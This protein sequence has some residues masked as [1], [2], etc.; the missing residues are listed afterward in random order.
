MLAKFAD[1]VSQTLDEIKAQ[2]LFK[3]ERIITGPQNAKIPIADG[4]RVINLC[5]NNYL[6]LA[7]HPAIVAAAKEALDTWALGW[8]ASASFAGRK[9]SQG[10]RSR[11]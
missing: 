6:G 8:P 5:A 10:T 1:H 3:T 2:G 4:R 7:N 9:H 11:A